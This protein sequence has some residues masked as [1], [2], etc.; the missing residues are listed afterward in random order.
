VVA[1]VSRIWSI[2]AVLA[3]AGALLL[4]TSSALAGGPVATK[5]GALINY[6]TTGRL[7]I[8][9]K[10]IVPFQC[11]VNCNVV[12]SVTVKGPGIHTTDTESGSLQAGVPSG[13]FI[14]PNGPLKKA[15]RAAP[16]RFKLI[17]RVNATDPATG[18]TDS[19]SHAFRLKR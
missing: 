10:I 17:S 2:A 18:A 15:M 5:S 12:S 1:R 9:K 13:H 19:I 16:G 6:L 11:A 7:K 3:V 4:P 8:G 14:K